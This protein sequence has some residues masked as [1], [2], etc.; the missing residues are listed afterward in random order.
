MGYA[1][2][3]VLDAIKVVNIDLGY[4]LWGTVE[5]C[6]DFLKLARA[7]GVLLCL[8]AAVGRL[9]YLYLLRV[10]SSHQ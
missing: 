4:V 7:W 9:P 10:V 3:A 6:W 8:G 1:S 2:A 5:F